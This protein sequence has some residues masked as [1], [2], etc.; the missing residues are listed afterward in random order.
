MEKGDDLNSIFLKV[1]AEGIEL[2]VKAIE[3]ISAKGHIASHRQPG[4]TGRLYQLK[5][6]DADT[7]R[8]C[9]KNLEEGVIGQYLSMKEERDSRVKLSGYVP[10]EIFR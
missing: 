10:P 9:L 5:D 6:F 3:Q 2:I 8:S 4:N 7:G 1:I